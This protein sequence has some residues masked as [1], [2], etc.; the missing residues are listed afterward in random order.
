M[1]KLWWE[2]SDKDAWDKNI[3]MENLVLGK[4]WRVLG[5]W[6]P[7]LAHTSGKAVSDPRP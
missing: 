5:R 1:L 6:K 7:G 3:S 4:P 2:R